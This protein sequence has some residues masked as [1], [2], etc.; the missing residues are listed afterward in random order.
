MSLRS[1]VIKYFEGLKPGT[2]PDGKLFMWMSLS[3]DSK[4]LWDGA[5]KYANGIDRP[6]QG[7]LYPSVFAALT[8]GL[9]GDINPE[10]KQWWSF[11]V[12]MHQDPKTGLYKN[13]MRNDNPEIDTPRKWR[14]LTE[15]TLIALDYLNAKPCYELSFLR[16]F[17]DPDHMTKWLDSL[18]WDN[19]WKM[20]NWVLEVAMM[21]Q[22]ERDFMGIPG[23]Q[24]G[25]DAWFDWHDK[26]QC[27]QTGFWGNDT[28]SRFGRMSPFGGPY[29]ALYGAYH[30]YLVYYYEG[31][32]I[33]HHQKIVDT[34][35]ELQHPN[36]SF[37]EDG[38]NGACEDI[39]AADV[40]VNFA[41][42]YNYRVDDIRKS[43]GR[44]LPT[45]FEHQREDGG[46]VYENGKSH[47]FVWLEVKA[48]GPST[49]I[50][51]DGRI[52]RPHKHTTVPA[53]T[54][55]A[56]AT[57]FR[58]LSLA[59]MSRVLDEPRIKGPWNFSRC[60]GF[61]FNVEQKIK[62]IERNKFKLFDNLG[63]SG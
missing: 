51:P 39:D 38:G 36:G 56:F 43:L 62:L 61:Q 3:S 60:P 18:D 21:L 8:K 11:T 16:P 25:L 34:V 33:N 26:H 45:I 14:H 27:A 10:E 41:L 42:L 4:R 49:K 22:Y 47:T 37:K 54:T 29:N 46:F 55:T 58:M 40:L 13:V 19:P 15:H 20:S 48:E 31:R 63:Q 57:W 59:S 52:V 24:P 1:D 30:Q 7:M 2:N 50:L 9:C 6:H 28:T 12:N 53:D 23:G 35:L 32:P 44:L 17:H 5:Y